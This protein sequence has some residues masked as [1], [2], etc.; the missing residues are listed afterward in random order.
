MHKY[1]HNTGLSLFSHQVVPAVVA[2]ISIRKA[3]HQLLALV[4][5]M[6]DRKGSI[7]VLHLCVCVG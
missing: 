7:V 3:L 1:Q 6:V 4:R 5:M 2:A